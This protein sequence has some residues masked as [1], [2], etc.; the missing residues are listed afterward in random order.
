MACELPFFPNAGNYVSDDEHDTNPRKVGFLILGIGLFTKKADVDTLCDPDDIIIVYT[1]DQA[2]RR[3]NAHCRKR[4]TH[5]N[6]F[7]AESS[8]GDEGSP[9]LA[10]SSPSH[11]RQRVPARATRAPPAAKLPHE[12]ACAT[13]TTRATP[14]AKLPPAPS[15]Q[16]SARKAKESPHPVKR[17]AS[18]AS[19]TVKSK[20]SASVKRE[21]RSPCKPLPLYLDSDEDDED[22]VATCVD[23]PLPLYR[24]DSPPSDSVP[25]RKRS[26]HAVVSTPTAGA[27]RTKGH[28]ASPPSAAPSAVPEPVPLSPS[29]SSLSSISTASLA[30]TASSS[31]SV[32]AARRVPPAP[33]SISTASLRRVPPVPPSISTASLRRVPPAPP[34]PTPPRLGPAVTAPLPCAGFG[35]SAAAASSASASTSA[36][37]SERLLYNIA[38]R[39]LY[40]DAE[41]A[42]RE[43][44][45]TDT[46]L[47][48]DC[49]NVVEYCAGQSGKMAG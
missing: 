49:T 8:S 42:V 31:A 29:A 45:L 15:A 43:M 6:D 34:I 32:M 5:S 27:K 25:S 26:L 37:P 7:V 44:E 17:E 33:P 3:W 41:I 35:Q 2:R 39:T 19:V 46:V 13:R 16:T 18:V 14:A 21:A 38:K 22:D 30:T 11:V 23:V 47:V 24:D 40:K 48:V 12:P 36:A 4:H 20:A 9:S 10:R 1:K 28:T